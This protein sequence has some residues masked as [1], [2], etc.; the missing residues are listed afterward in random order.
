M[1]RRYN[2]VWK[3]WEHLRAYEHDGQAWVEVMRG[4][5]DNAAVL[6][7]AFLPETYLSLIHI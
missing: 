1:G 7:S 5:Q 3:R 2:D 4:D 6:T